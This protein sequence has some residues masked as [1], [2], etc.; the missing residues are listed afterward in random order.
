MSSFTVD[1]P[2]KNLAVTLNLTAC[3]TL[4]RAVHEAYRTV[5]N[6]PGSAVEVSF[7][8]PEKGITIQIV[9]HK[10]SDTGWLMRAV[11]EAADGDTVGPY[12]ARVSA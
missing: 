9:V 1:Y 12:P 2:V 7:A 4:R 3:G 11:E 8:W 6:L 10:D 5:R